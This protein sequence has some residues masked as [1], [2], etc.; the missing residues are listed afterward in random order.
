[1]NKLIKYIK[2]TFNYAVDLDAKQYS[3]NAKLKLL[4]KSKYYVYI[5]PIT[6]PLLKDKL[7]E[8]TELVKTALNEWANALDNKI[9]F[10]IINTMHNADIKLYWVK[11]NRTF[12]GMQYRE[13]NANLH[14]L[15]VSIGIMNIDYCPY[16]AN[17]IYKIILHEFGHIF[18]LGHSD[19]I[20]DVM[21]ADWN[22]AD[23]ISENDKLVLNLI[24]SIGDKK[25]YFESENYIKEY[26]YKKQNSNRIIATNGTNLL[27]NL[28][29]IAKFKKYLIVKSI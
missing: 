13:E 9:N 23:K 20:N 24:Y 17:E 28:I 5:T 2:S 14:T 21:C 25:S 18:G 15:C 27:N 1:M 19:D 7:R 26:L 29:D 16:S 8:N 6:F 10:E 11:E 3:T 12:A 22:K 4:S